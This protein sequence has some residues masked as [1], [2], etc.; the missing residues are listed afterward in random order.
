MAGHK[1]N[2]GN[3]LLTGLMNARHVQS[4]N[5]TYRIATICSA[6]ENVTHA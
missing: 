5:G 1:V 2:V 4:F 6:E 3:D